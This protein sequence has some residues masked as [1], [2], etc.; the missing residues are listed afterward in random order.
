MSLWLTTCTAPKFSL[1]SL[2]KAQLDVWTEVLATQ[3]SLLIATHVYVT[4]WETLM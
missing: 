3:P 4:V 1:Q 2:L